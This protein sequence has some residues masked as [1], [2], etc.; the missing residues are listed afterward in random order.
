MDDVIYISPE[1]IE[2]LDMSDYSIDA[3]SQFSIVPDIAKPLIRSAK[4]IFSKIENTLYSAPAFIN[5]IKSLGPIETL[6]AVLSDEQREKI[7]SGA[8]API[9]RFK[10]AKLTGL[11]YS[12]ADKFI[13]T[14]CISKS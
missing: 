9:K 6:Q 13:K 5:A 11:D 3:E 7:A 12:G 14:S 1:D 8:F 4:S 10:S 2:I